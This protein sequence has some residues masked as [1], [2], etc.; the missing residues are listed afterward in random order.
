MKDND[1]LKSDSEIK[2]IFHDIK[3]TRM[4]V[5]LQLTTFIKFLN[6]VCAHYLESL[7]ASG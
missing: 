5:D 2:F 7:H 1:P 4:E 3:G 6:P